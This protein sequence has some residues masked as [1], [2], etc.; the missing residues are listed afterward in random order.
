M[1]NTRTPARRAALALAASAFVFLAA[2]GS[3]NIVKDGALKKDKGVPTTEA[4]APAPTTTTLPSAAGK[5]CKP[6]TPSPTDQAG[7]TTTTPKGKPVSVLMP[8]GKPPTKLEKSDLKVGTGELVTKTSQVNVNYIGI[9]CSTG[10]Q[11]DSSWDRGE[12]FNVTLG[13]TPPGVIE[14]WEQG[15]P[16]MKVGGQRELVIP[17]ALGYGDSGSGEIA[18][19]E[20]LVFIVEV[21]SIGAA[22]TTT[23]TVPE[24]TTTVAATTTTAADATTTTEAATTTTAG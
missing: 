2:C 9:A 11:F 24:T 22:P 4:G 7:S 18:P 21:V 16:G 17:P 13:Q 19:G 23:T 12:T 14:G 20:T 3:E 15:L 5:A 10:K 6:Y 1:S 8:S